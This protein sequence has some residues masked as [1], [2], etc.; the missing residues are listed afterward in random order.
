MDK[1]K[2]NISPNQIYF[3]RLAVLQNGIMKMFENQKSGGGIILSG[4]IKK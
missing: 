3:I 1:V 2:N 4:A